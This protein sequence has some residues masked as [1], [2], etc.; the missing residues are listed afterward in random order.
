M[1][2][3]LK[4]LMMLIALLLPGIPGSL[5]VRLFL[6]KIIKNR[7]IFFTAGLLIGDG[8]VS[9]LIYTL[10]FYFNIPINAYSFAAVYCILTISLIAFSL[11]RCNYKDGNR[12][13]S[14]STKPQKESKYKPIFLFLIF[15]S[16]IMWVLIGIMTFSSGVS[17]W[18]GI[19]IWGIKGKIIYH[20][21]GCLGFIN[22]I[23]LAYSHQ[24]YP[25]GYALM[26]TWCWYFIGGPEHYLIKM[27]P[28]FWGLISFI[29]L[30]AI[31]KKVLSN[32]K[33]SALLFTLFVCS[34]PAFINTTIKMYADLVLIS[35]LL[36]GFYSLFEWIKC[37]NIEL[38]KQR[39]MY[40]IGGLIMLIF[41]CW[42][43]SEGIVYLFCAISGIII[44]VL[45]DFLKTIQENIIKS[46]C[47]LFT[48]L[49]LAIIPWFNSK[50]IYNI[51]MRDFSLKTICFNK[52]RFHEI[53]LMFYNAFT[54][55]YGIGIICLVI[56]FF[57]IFFIRKDFFK[58]FTLRKIK[59]HI[60]QYRLL[61][62]MLY[63]SL[64]PILIF[65]VSFFASRMPLW[66]H[67]QS[68]QRIL[69]FPVTMLSLTLYSS[70]LKIDK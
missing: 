60:L 4:I 13:N 17:D 9:S 5:A 62:F 43:K 23:E 59:N 63:V 27:I 25:P 20:T 28:F 29:L 49:A 48:A 3:I 69:I 50:I 66:W 26:L 64:L 35:Y 1:E 51:H 34:T 8:I 19:G 36:C 21:E 53:S 41:S 16:I 31:T 32:R 38:K 67:L 2:I 30:Y 65:Y 61:Y 56:L 68:V 24:A 40:L 15:V 10:W 52:E 33:N 44:F 14:Q 42:Y 22:N 55:K 54:T 70:L 39:S 12:D 58:H 46:C 18:P 11:K 6:P 7:I 37:E 47:L 45:R 57:L